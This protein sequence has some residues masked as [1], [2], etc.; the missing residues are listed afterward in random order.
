MIK[1]TEWDYLNFVYSRETQ[2]TGRLVA[3]WYITKRFGL[4]WRCNY[5]GL[6]KCPVELGEKV[7]EFQATFSFYTSLWTTCFKNE[8]FL[9][10]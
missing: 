1:E 10:L 7:G 6:Y 4:Y 9:V 3:A 8:W 5:F 2:T